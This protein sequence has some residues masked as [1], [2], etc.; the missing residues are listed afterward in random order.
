MFEGHINKAGFAEPRESVGLRQF[1]WTE[2]V[3]RLAA[4]RELSGEIAR[5]GEGDFS[6]FGEA[7]RASEKGKRA[8]NQDGLNDGKVSDVTRSATA[9]D[10]AHGDREKE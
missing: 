9:P 1:C 6:A 5:T 10:A 4:T 8:V 2:L 7:R 3:A